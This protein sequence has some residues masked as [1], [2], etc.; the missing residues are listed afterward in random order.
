MSSLCFS[1]EDSS[2]V[3]RVALLLGSVDKAKLSTSIQMTGVIFGSFCFGQMADLFGRKKVF[4]LAS[5]VQVL[6]PVLVCILMT[7]SA[8]SFSPSMDV[9][10]LIRFFVGFSTSG[11]NTVG[12]V[13]IVENLPRAHRLWLCTVVTWAP[14]YMLFALLAYLTGDWRQ[15]ARVGNAFVVPAILL[16]GL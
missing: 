7:A 10:L 11:A 2:L 6:L 8:S 3:A 1:R 16:L 5:H 9:F 14:N 15:L 4:F 13:F 12:P